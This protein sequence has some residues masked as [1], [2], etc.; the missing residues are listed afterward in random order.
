MTHTNHRQGSHE[1]LM[2]DW[3]VMMIGAPRIN[4]EDCKLK[5]KKFLQLSLKYD[6]VNAGTARTGTR[7]TIGWQRFMDEVEKAGEDGAAHTVVFDSVVKVAAF[8][9]NLAQADLGLSVVISGLHA[10]TD[11]MCREAGTRRHTVQHS[12]G[13]W[14]KTELL[15]HSK[16]LELTTMCGH[17]MIPFNLVRHMANAVQNGSLSLEQAAVE[18][19][20]PCLCGVFNTK[21]AQALLQEY[22]ACTADT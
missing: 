2:G 5:L 22:I 20:K 15:P 3:V 21:R 14:G 16:I 7:F 8:L 17:G 10:E 1:S 11:R 6:P 4:D 19:A 13:V 12:L 9:K 18:L